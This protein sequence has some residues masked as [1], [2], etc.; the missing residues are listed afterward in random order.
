MNTRTSTSL[1]D[2]A[3]SDLEPPMVSTGHCSTQLPTSVFREFVAG[4]QWR[5]AEIESALREA[6]AGDFAT[7]SELT[8]F[9]HKWLFCRR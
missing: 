7:D 2:H 8:S 1:D 4:R 9:A 6:D 5:F 3:N